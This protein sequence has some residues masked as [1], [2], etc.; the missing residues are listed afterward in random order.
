MSKSLHTPP[1]EAPFPAF[2]ALLSVQ[3]CV[4]VSNYLLPGYTFCLSN[5]AAS[6][7]PV[8]RW[9]DEAARRLYG[10]RRAPE[11]VARV[12]LILANRQL[13]STVFQ[14]R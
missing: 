14:V 6:L 4:G 9:L 2:V 7:C 11:I 10:E 3:L 13:S 12:S 8:P 1:S 5:Q